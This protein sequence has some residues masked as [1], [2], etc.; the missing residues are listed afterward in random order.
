[1]MLLRIT[2]RA[3]E[4]WNYD[5]FNYQQC[6]LHTATQYLHEEHSSIGNMNTL[7]GIN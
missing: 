2:N 7:H 5:G 3:A 4:C 1:M 6:V